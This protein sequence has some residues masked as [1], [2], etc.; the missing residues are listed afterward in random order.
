M[1][2]EKYLR[3][4]DD[5]AEFIRTAHPQLKKKIREAL[6]IISDD[7]NVG[8]SLKDEL[9]GLKSFR[10]SRFRIIY[11]VSPHRQIEIV[12]IGHRESI[13]DEMLKILRC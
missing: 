1:A 10:I 3:I 6:E 13:Y 4:P 9:S 5:V 12:A 11:R 2:A 8:K 7:P